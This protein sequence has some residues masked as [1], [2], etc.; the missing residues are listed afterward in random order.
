MKNKIL[1]VLFSITGLSIAIGFGSKIIQ[2]KKSN[3]ASCIVVKSTARPKGWPWRGISLQSGKSDYQDIQYLNSCGINFVRIQLK[4][5]K[6][7]ENGK[8]KPVD[9]FYN[10]IAW[11]DKILDECKKYKMTALIAD[12]YLVLDPNDDVDDKSKEFWQGN[13][14][15]DSAYAQINIICNHFKNRGDELSAY[16]FIGEPAIGSDEFSKAQSPPRLEEFFNN[17]LKIIRKYDK[18]R[19]LLL[20]PG[21]FGKPL[22]YVGFKGFNIK[23]DK[24]IY[25]AH[26]YLPMPFTHQGIKNRPRGVEYPGTIAGKYWDK[27]ALIKTF[28]SLKTFESKTGYPIYIGEF[29][30]VRWAPNCNQWVKDVADII[31]QYNW[32]WS[33][34]AYQPDY[35][36]WNPFMEVKNPNDNMK[37]WKLEN[38][39]KETAI[40]KY[41]ITT[42]YKKSNK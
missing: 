18:N 13:T 24:L 38:K 26:M 21:P 32:G 42:L 39:G 33:Y 12:N 15:M 10:E 31:S 4:P 37:E 25:G 1:L 14:Y 8:I 17:T 3:A 16:E 28:N 34:F 23:D 27:N 7:T 30:S 20:T 6:R 9:A 2:G 41:F 19:F 5:C 11:A 35:D 40:W 22:N 29:Q 36:F